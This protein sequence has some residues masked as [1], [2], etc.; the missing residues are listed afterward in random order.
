MR[1][2]SYILISFLFI[3]SA[4]AQ[5]DCLLLQQESVN[6]N[7]QT[8][9]LLLNS[10]NSEG[11]IIKE[12]RTITDFQGTYSEKNI[13]EYT[14]KGYLSK[15]SNFHND[16]FRSAKINNYNNLGQLLAVT[17]TT[18]PNE[19]NTNNTLTTSSLNSEKLF[20]AEDNTI[21][22]K[23]TTTKNKNGQIL[24]YEISNGAG[25][26]NHSKEFT[27][28]PDGDKTYEKRNDVV[29]GMVEEIFT[30]YNTSSGKI[31]KD[32]TYLNGK[33]IGRTFY[34]YANGF[35]SEKTIFGRNN[36]L[37]YEIQYVNNVRGNVIKES[38]L[39]QGRLLN[40]IEKSYDP[41]GNLTLEKSFDTNN[42]LLKAK[43]WEYRC[44]K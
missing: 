13:F 30:S 28:S 38:F 18:D 40:F 20:F 2:F 36:K 5:A 44:P 9:F 22:A 11:Q 27:Y 23:E 34:T 12:N 43:T 3:G 19:L 15:V 21:S 14:A 17:E 31:E 6:K 35:L 32:S 4:H 25:M 29:G 33:L 7:G 1:F 24:N 39:Y 42:N 37:D 26:V 8:D 10:Y 16:V 41:F